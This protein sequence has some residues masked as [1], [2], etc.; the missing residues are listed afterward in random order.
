MDMRTETLQLNPDKT[1]DAVDKRPRKYPWGGIVIH[2]TGIGNRTK[3]EDKTLWSKLYSSMRSWL[4][5]KDS[6]ELSAHYLIGRNGELSQLVDPDKFVAYH[7]GV[8]SYWLPELRKVI[9]GC[10][11]HFIGI[12]LIGDGNKQEFSNE[13]YIR[14]GEV[15]RYLLQEYNINP[16]MI[17]GH[18]MIAPGRKDDPGKLFCWHDLYVEIYR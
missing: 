11:D 17:V 9:N 4:S 14:C 16:N 7:A 5:S 3:I 6:N 12:E 2:H 18:E 8:S 13:Q 1:L 15:C 10:N